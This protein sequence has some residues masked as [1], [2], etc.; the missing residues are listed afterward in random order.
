M[1]DDFKN[2]DEYIKTGQPASY[3]DFIAYVKLLMNSRQKEKIRKLLDFHFYSE[4]KYKLSKKRLKQLELL[5]QERASI[6]SD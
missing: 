6:L 3:Q 4:S 2:I 5:I 1:E